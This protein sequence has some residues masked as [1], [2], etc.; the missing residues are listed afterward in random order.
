MRFLDGIKLLLLISREQRPDLGQRV[1]HYSFHFLHRLLMDG[2]D[3]R[4]SRIENWLNLG[5]LIRSQVQFLG[6]PI[7]TKLVAVPGTMATGAGLSLQRDKTAKRDRTGGQ[8]C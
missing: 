5:L 8:K 4:L 7:E 6:D 3:L 1:V 2:A